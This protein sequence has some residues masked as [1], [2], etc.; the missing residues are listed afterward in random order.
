MYGVMWE[1]FL[2]VTHFST[3]CFCVSLFTISVIDLG[4]WGRDYFNY[5]KR[6]KNRR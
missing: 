5:K 2:T 4:I 6:S 3:M 1:A